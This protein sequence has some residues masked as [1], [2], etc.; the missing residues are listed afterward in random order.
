MTDRTAAIRAELAPVV[1]SLDLSIYDV[2]IGGGDRPTLAIAIHRA[3]GVDLDAL[4]TATRAISATLD[5]LDPVPGRYLLEVTSPGLERALRTPDHFAAA[6]GELVTLKVRDAEGTVER[7]RGEVT[8][9]DVEATT[10]TLTTDD[11]ARTVSIGDVESARTIFEWGPQPKPGS[12]SR[13]GRKKEVAA[14]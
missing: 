1:E 11:T 6:M 2:T 5:A 14:R 9:V 4:E 7:L 8:A 10:V 13:P 12:G 3:G